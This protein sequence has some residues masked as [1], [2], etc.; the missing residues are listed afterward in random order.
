LGFVWSSR[1]LAGS[2]ATDM[3]KLATQVQVTSGF[4]RGQAQ[5]L[6]LF[7]QAVSNINW[8]IDCNLGVP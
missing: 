2:L 1:L 5:A 8:K 6:D 3:P 7:P 4:G